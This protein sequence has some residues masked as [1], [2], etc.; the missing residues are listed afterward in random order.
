MASSSALPPGDGKGEDDE[1]SI[2]RAALNKMIKELIPTVRV[3]NDAR[4]LIL[5]CC[6][7]FIHFVSSEANDICNKQNKKTISPEHI[8]AALENLGF[9][10]YKEDAEAVLQET[11]AV[12]AKKRRASSRLENLGIPEEEL[13]RQQQELFAKARQEQAEL[14][15][16]QWIQMQQA[17]QEQQNMLQQQTLSPEDDYS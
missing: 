2:P 1:L 11:K 6:T 7:E 10:A 4:E 15:Q 8:L 14:E 12:A 3:A 16:Q 5:N 17:L 13:L 9:G